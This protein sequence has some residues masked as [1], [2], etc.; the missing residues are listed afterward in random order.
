MEHSKYVYNTYIFLVTNVN[1]GAIHFIIMR[2]SADSI[3]TYEQK[4]NGTKE[5]KRSIELK[6]Q[7]KKIQENKKGKKMDKYHSWWWQMNGNHLS[8]K[9][10]DSSYEILFNF[11]F[12]P[13]F[14]FQNSLK[15]VK[16][17][18]FLHFMTLSLFNIIIH[19]PKIRHMDAKR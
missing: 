9:S 2:P 15:W 6:I 5:E 3:D 17:W 16:Y 13:F 18:R 4:E 1:S 12:F 7:Q 8:N 19:G 14:F 10:Q 11:F